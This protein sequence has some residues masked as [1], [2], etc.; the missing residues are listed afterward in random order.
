MSFS[1]WRNADIPELEQAI[2]DSEALALSNELRAIARLLGIED[3]GHL[4]APILEA[5]NLA[6]SRIMPSLPQTFF[7][8]V[9][10]QCSLSS[11]QVHII[12]PDWTA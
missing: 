4:A 8:P 12:A 7:Q 6:M 5:A 3:G 9:L 1:V 11:E 2:G 10:A